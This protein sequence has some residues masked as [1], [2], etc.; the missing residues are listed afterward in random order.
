MERYD[1]GLKKIASASKAEELGQFA[2][3]YD[4]YIAGIENL[5]E[6][7]KS[8]PKEE[9]GLLVRKHIS[10]F[11]DTA[12][13]ISKLAKPKTSDPTLLTKAK[14]AES[15][16]RDFERALKLQLA[17]NSYTEAAEHYRSRRLQSA[18]DTEEHR[19][20]G[21]SALAMIERAESLKRLLNGY[22]P[23]ITQDN[24]PRT[25]AVGVTPTGCLPNNLVS[26]FIRSD[27]FS[28]DEERKV[29]LIGSKIYGRTYE[30]M[31]ASDADP[32]K[33][34]GDGW[35]DPDGL[36]K[37][38]PKQKAAGAV[39]GRP[40]M[41]MERPVLISRLSAE[42]IT[43]TLVGDCS[44]VSSLALCAA[45][46]HRFKRTLISQNIYPQASPLSPPRPS[47]LLTIL[48]VR[49]GRVRAGGVVFLRVR[50][51]A[52]GCAW[53]TWGR[54]QARR[55][56]EVGPGRIGWVNLS[57]ARPLTKRPCRAMDGRLKAGVAMQE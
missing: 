57:P 52:A 54:A 14:D 49:A 10:K 16:A 17:F 21:E 55:A 33:F 8:E 2:E 25:G 26:A 15:R 7:V 32:S 40:G 53:P 56:C 35:R 4:L 37:L 50:A 6:T 28:S 34:N 20:A 47:M 1:E 5:L 36:P 12:E 18:P 44:F 31:Y 48:L 27:S 46:E 45:W 41:F 11:M 3:A 51:D 22:T 30:L 42:S 29:L 24:A 43:Q 38:C 13:K 23:N 39:W 9:L 19:I